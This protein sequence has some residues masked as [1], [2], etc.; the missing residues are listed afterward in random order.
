MPLEA[1]VKAVLSGDTVV[2]SHIT[3]PG[4]ERTLSLAYVS[5]PRLRREGDEA[6]AFQS[7]EFLRE[8]LVGKVVQFNVLYTIPTGAKRDY[9]TIKLPTF[10]VLLPDISV[11]EGWV[12]V[13]E[14]A[15]KR[16]DESEETAALLQRL[17]ALEEHAQSEDK[18]VWAGAEKGHTETTYELSDG[19]ALIEE[20][21]NKPLEAIVERVL[22]GD[23]LVLRLLLTPQEHLQVVVAVAGVRAP[24][25]R[26]VNAEGKEQPAE[27]FGDDAH[28]FVESRLQQRKVQ[29]SLLGVTPQGQLIATVLHPNGNIAKF[30]LEE[31]LARCHDL[32]A[33]LLG[34][35]M[36]SFRRAEKA[37]KDAR[38]GLFTGLVAKGP[39]GGAAEDYIVS[40]VLNADTLFLRNKAGQ[41][42]KISL[43]SVRQPKPSDPKQAPFAADAKEFVRKRLIG[44]HVKVSINGKKPATEG[45]EERDVATVIYGNTNIALALVEAGYASVIRHRQDDDDRSPDYDSLLIAEADAQKDGKGMW[46]PKPPKAKQYQD[47]SES[48]QKAKM[49]VSILQRQKRVPAI[50]DFVK[51]GSRF[52]VLVPRENAKL[53]L[54]LS[55]IRAPRSARNP[56]EQSEPFGQ[57]A[58]DLANRR[59]MQRD[60]E[61]DVETIDKVGGF[62]GTLYVNKENFT[63]VLLEEGFATVHAYSAE[64]SGHATEYFAAEQKAKEARK[65]LWHDWDPS[66]DVEEEEEETTDTNGANEAS[67]RGKDYRDVMVTYV[68]PTNGRLKIQQIGTGTS[69]LTELMNAFRSF[70]LNKAND[71]P[72]PGPPKAGDF[73]AAKFTEDN[74]WYRAKVRRNDREK[75]QAEVLYIDFG[76]SEVLPWSRLRP[77]SQPQFSVQKLR[78]QAVDAVLSMA[79]LPGS[80]DY[81]QDAADFLEEQL[82]NR[83]LVANVDY[84]SPEGT[85]HVTLM[86]PTE[87]K[88]LD[89]SINADLI[90]EGLA[91]VPRKLK[92]W[93]RSAAETL[94]HLR[95]QEDEAKQERRVNQSLFH[96]NDPKQHFNFPRPAEILKASKMPLW[97]TKSSQES[98]N[99]ALESDPKN[100]PVA[101]ASQAAGTEWLAGHLNHLTEDQEK[102]LQ[103]F[104]KLCEENGYYKPASDKEAA[105]HDDATI[106]RFLRARKFDVNG[107]WGQ[108]K[109]TEDWRKENAIESLYENIDV[110]SYDAARRM[111]PQWTGRRDRRGIPVYVFEIK[112]LNSKNMAAYNSTMTDPSATAE[113]HKSS[114]VPQ[115]LLRLFA[116]Y[117]NLLRFVMPLC[118]QL[119]RPHPDTPI[120]SSNNIVDV[121]GVGLKQFWNLK[122]HMQDASV[123]ATAHYPETLDRIFIIGAPSFFPTVWGWI[124]RWFDPVTT[125]KIFILSSAEVLP[126]LSSFMDPTTIPK[127]YGG[128]LDWQWGDM[129]N[130]DDEA[131]KLV[132]GLETPPAEGETKPSFIKGPVLFKGDHVEILGKVNGESR[133]SSVPVPVSQAAESTTPAPEQQ[134]PDDALAAENEDEHI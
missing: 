21:K 1:R 20:Y 69:A 6:Y 44:K 130:L 86:D 119:S 126:T 93:E 89:H 2:L 22:N 70:H 87:S 14:E 105:S 48:V 125:S 112:H 129:P 120:V 103:E 79:Q 62:I 32:H 46:S 76:N 78:A 45:Y 108:F 98:D 94:S 123:L 29:V 41:E 95:S 40:R 109:D 92:A 16:A 61:I 49:E 111:Y 38:K 88:N 122:G 118:S 131:R 110:E 82:Y 13:R 90:R 25:A 99:A 34:A 85:L 5:A 15:G 132:G 53:T 27:P 7:R 107:A 26:R 36:A 57:E 68:D 77:L 72:L 101:S 106:L 55:G 83:E 54:V 23:R 33:P 52:T 28:Q 4:Q 42:K 11:Q 71:T 84:V 73:V 121:S 3:N 75:Q 91:M 133:K 18:G 74:E 116:L 113:T 9:G 67:Q 117:E 128:Q 96:P 114:T 37:A 80:G 59:C 35:D 10:E 124:K 24:A 97:G 19:K 66:K 104:K 50:V 30:L 8:L 39:A 60:V 115:R 56:N 47:Y 102:K 64:Q 127:Q 17:R 100:D 58:H 31:G 134:K 65:G 63:K 43:S 81:L 12:R 51:S